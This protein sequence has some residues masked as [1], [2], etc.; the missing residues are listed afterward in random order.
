LQLLEL[1]GLLHL[2]AAVFFAPAIEGLLHDPSL[3]AGLRHGLALAH[4]HFD[5]T[6]LTHDLLGRERFLRH[7]PV[8]FCIP[9][10]IRLVQKSPVIRADSFQS[11]PHSRA[12]KKKTP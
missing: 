6:Q 9:V 2:Q 8:P 10:S 3:L 5:L 11:N 12:S 1:F 4:Q 7:F